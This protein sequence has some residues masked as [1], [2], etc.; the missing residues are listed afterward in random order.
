MLRAK[1]LS[2][3]TPKELDPEMYSDVE[4][5]S[6]VEVDGVDYDLNFWFDEDKFK[7]TA[8]FLTEEGGV[9]VTDN[10]RFFKILTKTCKIMEGEE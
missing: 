2:K 1:I 10:T 9:T 7:V 3:L 4:S 6:A 8:H 5:W